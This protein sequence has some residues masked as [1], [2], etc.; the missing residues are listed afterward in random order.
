MRGLRARIVLLTMA[1]TLAPTAIFG[2]LEL[3]KRP[4]RWK[5]QVLAERQ[6]SGDQRG[7]TR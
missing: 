6:Q 7:S 1:G 4:A 5:T 3:V 2:W